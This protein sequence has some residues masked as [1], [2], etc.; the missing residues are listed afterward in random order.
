MPSYDFFEQRQSDVRYFTDQRIEINTKEILNDYPSLAA[1]YNTDA[2]AHVFVDAAARAY[3]KWDILSL[4]EQIILNNI[5]LN[6][7]LRKAIEQGFRPQED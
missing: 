3:D 1:I 4:T 2:T 6:A 5:R 7:M